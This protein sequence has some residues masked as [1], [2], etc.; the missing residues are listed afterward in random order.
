MCE[1][2]LPVPTT[3]V[4][5]AVSSVVTHEEVLEVTLVTS[6]GPVKLAL[7]PPLKRQS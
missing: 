2:C 7:V 6:T 4:G 1:L 5:Q 3:H